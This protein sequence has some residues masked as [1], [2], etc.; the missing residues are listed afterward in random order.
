[1]AAHWWE[2]QTHSISI[3]V[4]LPASTANE[5]LQPYSTPVS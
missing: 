2:H 3:P 4:Q 5:E 1:M